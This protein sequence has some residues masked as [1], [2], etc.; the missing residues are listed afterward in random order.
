[1]SCDRSVKSRLVTISLRA[2][3][4]SLR[5]AHSERAMATSIAALG[6]RPLALGE[7]KVDSMKRGSARSIVF[8][9]TVS[10]IWRKIDSRF[11][12]TTHK[13]THILFTV[14]FKSIV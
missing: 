5:F 13:F 8:M 1:M 11:W 10:I 9:I 3:L 2:P 6:S 4:R 12:S 14:S 7:L